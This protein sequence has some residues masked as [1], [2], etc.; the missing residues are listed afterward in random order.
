MSMGNL[1]IDQVFIDEV[2][3]IL[4]KNQMDEKLNG[5]YKLK[6]VVRDGIRYQIDTNNIQPVEQRFEDMSI[7][8]IAIK[9]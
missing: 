2:D 6:E 4:S 8:I 5:V 3:F 9:L 1:K 7:E